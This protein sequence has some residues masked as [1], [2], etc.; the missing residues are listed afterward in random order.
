MGSG[1]ERGGEGEGQ[2]KENSL[3]Q[4]CLLPS[5]C[6]RSQER[7]DWLSRKSKKTYK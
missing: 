7:G 2:S 4:R 5:G 6:I 3:K 1:A